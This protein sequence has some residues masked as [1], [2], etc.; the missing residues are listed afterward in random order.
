MSLY[1]HQELCN[2]CFD[3]Q[4]PSSSLMRDSMYVGAEFCAG[5]VTGGD[6]ISHVGHIRSVYVTVNSAVL[7]HSCAFPWLRT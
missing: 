5:A 1:E 6:P 7:A 3:S 2:I 4:L